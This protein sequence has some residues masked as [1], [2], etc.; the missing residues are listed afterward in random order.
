MAIDLSS[1]ISMRHMRLLVLVTRV[2]GAPSA[3]GTGNIFSVRCA[4]NVFLSSSSYTAVALLTPRSTR[5]RKSPS[6]LIT[7]GRWCVVRLCRCIVAPP[8]PDMECDIPHVCVYICIIFLECLCQARCRYS[9]SGS[10]PLS[11][12]AIKTEIRR[13]QV[14]KETETETETRMIG[15]RTREREPEP[16]Y[17]TENRAT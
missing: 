17:R 1:I 16:E 6:E 9:H 8:V 7:A 13:S 2:I 11:G 15:R 14:P 10:G 4:R 5:E 12:S 3:G